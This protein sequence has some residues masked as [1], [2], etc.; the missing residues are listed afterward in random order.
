MSDDAKALVVIGLRAFR[1]K[2][3]ARCEKDFHLVAQW[4]ETDW[5]CAAAGE[6]GEACNLIKKRRRGENV[7]V[8][9]V[10]RELA[11]AVTYLDLLACRLGIDLGQA[12]VDKFNEVSDRIGSSHRF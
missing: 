4:S 3:V 11:D 2:N 10:A 7:P 6:L 8:A 9:D 12:L 1:S 5:A